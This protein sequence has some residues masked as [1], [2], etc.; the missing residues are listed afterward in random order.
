MNARDEAYRQLSDAALPGWRLPTP[1]FRGEV[2]PQ[3]VNLAHAITRA[4]IKNHPLL[5]HLIAHYAGRPLRQ[6]DD[7]AQAVLAIGLAQLRYFDRLPDYA[8]VDEAAEQAK[9]LKL[10]KAVGFI[11][12][13]LRRAIREPDVPLPSKDDAE[14]YAEVVLSQPPELF[15]RLSKLLGKRDALRLAE[16]NNGEAPLIVRGQ[17][18]ATEG[19]EITPHE[20]SGFYVLR[21]ATESMLAEWSRAGIAQ[22]QDPT[23]ARVIDQLLLEDAK[24]VLDRCC[25]VGTKTLQIAAAA[26]KSQIIAMDPSEWRIH[27]LKRSIR[28]KNV[29]N[30]QPII[31]GETTVLDEALRFDRILIDAPCSNSGVL[32]RRPEAKYRQEEKTLRS[33]EKLQ[34]RILADT[35]SR[36]A[37]GGRLVYS[38]CSIWEEENEAQVQ[39]M[40][41][42]T[43][44]LRVVDQRLTLPSLE[45]DPTK[46]HDGGFVAVLTR[47]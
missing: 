43:P 24:T 25:G 2:S 13:V 7:R 1:K 32:I 31:A 19:V 20:E 12:A 6:I 18:P 15:R 30:I 28:Q 34:R 17:P 22:A 16:R 9:R 42:G 37:P 41:K 39:W 3:D 44:G 38:T 10:G 4:V 36:L 35:I 11:N 27:A 21:G 23:S 5:R 26:P 33:V 45:A 46:H 47:D 14:K 8:V 29:E 40:I